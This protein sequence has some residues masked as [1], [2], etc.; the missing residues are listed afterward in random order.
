MT[1][2]ILA[3]PAP[4]AL[5][6]EDRPRPLN[7]RSFDDR[8][9][10][11]GAAVGSLALVWLVYF[12]LLPFSGLVGFFIVWY[13]AFVAMY[14]AVSG[15]SHPK[16]EIVDRLVTTAMY[17][18]ALIVGAALTWT[19]VIILVKGSP[20]FF[21]ANFFTHDMTG[22]HPSD[23]LTHGGAEH[24]I[25]GSLIILGIAV[26]ISVPLGIGTAIFLTEVG[27]RVGVAVRTIVEAMTAVPDLLAGLFV[28][29]V[30]ILE[31]QQDKV[32]WVTAVAISVTMTP[33]VARSAEVALRVVPGG[34]REAG[35]AL[36]ASQWATVW[37]V[38]LPTA[39]PGLA[40]AMILAIARGVG[41]TAPLLIVSRSTTIFNS[42]PLNG[43]MNSLPL[44]IWDGVRSPIKQM[45]Q[46]GYGAAMML[47]LLVLVLF[48]V[49][50]LHSRR[51]VGQR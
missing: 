9:S 40:T 26:G 11:I 14:A 20:A 45:N 13:V 30:L 8:A 21:H 31:F 22:V 24:A 38:V 42:D 7:K 44:Y 37:R 36:G 5:P 48:V 1:A 47:L 46:R 34:L 16:T 6:P 27:G 17:A 15:L 18:A 19:I 29:V 3:A 39:L 41:E 28:Y 12:N 51:R 49:T 33:I 10:F 35:E 32:G 2:T 50:R 4:A 25:V 23:G 43:P